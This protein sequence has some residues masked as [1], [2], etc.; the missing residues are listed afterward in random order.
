MAELWINFDGADNSVFWKTGHRLWEKERNQGWNLVKQKCSSPEKLDLP[1]MKGK[2]LCISCLQIISGFDFQNI[3]FQLP[4]RQLCGNAMWSVEYTLLKFKK[5]Y[6]YG[7]VNLGVLT[8]LMAYQLWVWMLLQ[9]S[10]GSWR[11]G[12]ST[13]PRGPLALDFGAMKKS[14]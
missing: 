4:F 6:L 8:V 9:W 5:M 2:I 1:S 14:P 11:G 13:D 3:E 12:L 10:D 7:D